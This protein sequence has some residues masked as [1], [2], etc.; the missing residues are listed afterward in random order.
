MLPAACTRRRTPRYPSARFTTP[1]GQRKVQCRKTFCETRLYS[2][3]N[4]SQAQEALER[5][6]NTAGRRCWGE[7]RQAT[8]SRALVKALFGLRTGDGREGL[9]SFSPEEFK[10]ITAWG[11]GRRPSPA[12]NSARSIVNV[13]APGRQII[14]HSNHSD[15]IARPAN[16]AADP[17]FRDQ[18]TTGKNK[19]TQTANSDPNGT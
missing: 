8:A 11:V 2:T 16:G 7:N 6:H 15:A 9:P 1:P 17:N 3:E 18:L 13:V 4:P 12:S 14:A 5:L 10:R 19:I